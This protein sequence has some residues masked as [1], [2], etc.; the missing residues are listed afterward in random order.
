MKWAVPAVVLS[1]VFTYQQG[2][3]ARAGRSRLFLS[4]WSRSRLKKKPGAGA[5]R[6]K[7][8]SRS[9]LKL[10]GSTAQRED[11]KHKEL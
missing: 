8:R 11:K 5:A 1:I 6:K 7:V 9:R 10:A 3:G 4:P 2:L